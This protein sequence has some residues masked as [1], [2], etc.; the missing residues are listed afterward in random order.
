MRRFLSEL[1][2]ILLASV[3]QASWAQSAQPDSLLDQALPVVHVSA[4]KGPLQVVTGT[5]SS[6]TSFSAAPGIKFAVLFSSALG[7]YHHLEQV[8][9]RLH[10]AQTIQEGQLVFRLAS[11]HAT[12][13]PANDQLFTPII[14]STDQIRHN[15]VTVRWPSVQVPENGLFIVI[16]CLG[17]TA[18]EHVVQAV[19]VAHNQ[20]LMLQ[21]GSHQ[22]EMWPDRQVSTAVLPRLQGVK[23][24]INEADCWVYK[25][26]TYTWQRIAPH[27]PFISVSAS[28]GVTQSGHNALTVTE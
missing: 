18:D 15:R 25:P 20:P 16:E 28:F 9:L 14:L 22:Q 19:T 27:T 2:G 13:E 26:A 24:D 5:S 8:T 11:V 21:I 7:G 12:G 23:P 6:S 1:L 10:Q 4:A 3:S 17:R